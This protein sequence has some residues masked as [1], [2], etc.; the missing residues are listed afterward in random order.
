VTAK[1]SAP[2]LEGSWHQ[3]RRTFERLERY[4]EPL[5]LLLADRDVA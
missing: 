3:E 2:P 4:A 1:A 5:A